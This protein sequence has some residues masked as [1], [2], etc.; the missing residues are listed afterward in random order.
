VSNPQRLVLLALAVLVLA[1][2]LPTLATPYHWDELMWI[3]LAHRLAE[4]PLWQALPGCHP[5]ALFAGRPPGLYLPMAAAFK[6]TGPSLALSHLAIAG[7]AVLGV[8]F[9]YRLG[10][11]LYGATAGACAALFVF[12]NPMYFAQ[13]GMFL[14]DLPVTA[15]GVATVYW[16]LRRRYVPYLIWAVGLV[17]LKETALA[18]VFA[19]STYVLLSERR[20]GVAG[21]LRATLPWALPLLLMA[22]YYA[23]QKLTTGSFFVQLGEPF[24]LFQPRQLFAQLTQ[25]TRWLFVEQLRWVFTALVVVH[26][27]TDRAAR[28]RPE[29]LLVGLIVLSSG[30]AFSVL[31]FL[32][33]YLLP[34]LPY[35]CVLAAG[36]LV[37]L[38]PR[39]S[40]HV[41]LAAALVVVLA[42]RLRGTDRPG[43]REWDLGY[44]A[45]VRTYARTAEVL[46]RD[47]AGARIL[48]TWPLSQYLR[49]PE[50]GYVAHPLQAVRLRDALPLA[51]SE[52]FGVVVDPSLGDADGGALAA[53]ART[54]DLRLVDHLAVGSFRCDVYGRHAA[55]T[56]AATYSAQ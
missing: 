33:R 26:L 54:H 9:T 43:N 28:R 31:Y 22:L 13:A 16:A 3:G 53:Y 11:L 25:V 40:V 24:D 18:I 46:E 1:T 30:Y 37:E 4:L 15:C 12:F 45:A 50:L 7:F 2:K 56:T 49:R 32:P 48:T 23:V 19:V 44:L 52:R 29:L 42:L 10:T 35:L 55:D 34:V 36:A 20:R 27:A 8:W 47:Y 41:T 5:P 51:A 38:W 14:A 21:A 17:L 39:R 6:L